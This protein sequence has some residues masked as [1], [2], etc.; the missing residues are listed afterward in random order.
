MPKKSAAIKSKPVPK[1]KSGA[2]KAKP[3]GKS[4]TVW[5]IQSIGELLDAV[6]KET[7]GRIE[8]YEQRIEARLKSVE[9]WDLKTL[10][11]NVLAVGSTVNNFIL[12][13]VQAI[14]KK[15]GA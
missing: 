10:G 12:P 8:R 7:L 14:K 6:N 9:E 3:H 1:S 5:S 11:D 4:A 2:S 13:D 15:V